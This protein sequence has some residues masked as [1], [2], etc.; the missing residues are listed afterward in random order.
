MH[1]NSSSVILFLFLVLAA[2]PGWCADA[3]SVYP[4]KWT[5]VEA[6]RQALK[7]NPDA[8][9]ARHRIEAARAAIS[10]A[11]AAFY[12]RLDVG[13]EYGGTD[14]PMFSFGNILNHGS[15]SNTINF[16][17]PGT[18]D[19]L[20]LIASLRYRLYNGGRDQAGLAAAKAQ[21]LARQQQQ[22][23]VLSTLADQ[24][25]R[26][27]YT[28]V[29]AQEIVAARKSAVTA[30]TASLAVA[31]AR[32]AAG[33]L[34]KA[35]L[36][37][38][39]VQQSAA[40]ERLIQARHGHELA[41]RAFLNLLGL[42]LDDV[43]LDVEEQFPQ[44]VPDN[45]D[46]SKRPE[47]KSLDAM[48]QAAEK[49]LARARAGYLPTADLFA[50]YQV[51]QGFVNESDSGNS[52]MAGV[53]LN[54][55]LFEGDRTRAAIAAA[56]AEL[57]R[58]K[59]LKRKMELAITL[60]I[61][62]AQLALKQARERLVVT[63]KQVRLARESARLFRERFKEGVILASNLMDAENRLTDALVHASIARAAH[64]IAIADL[65]RAAGF[66]QFPET[67][68][69]TGRSRSSS[70]ANSRHNTRQS[71]GKT[72]DSRPNGPG[73]TKKTDN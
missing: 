56:T 48:I 58:A 60:E 35:N 39:E 15:F 17:D 53:R 68:T 2:T 13:A 57:A 8:S 38:I 55:N 33:D 64:K 19:N 67:Q 66:A 27:F 46:P 16:N 51:D 49:Q 47:I 72:T 42:R 45:P 52:W 6:V 63:D 54:Y 34:L 20:R 28:I 37:D 10:Q 59:E 44:Q 29:Q 25:V 36:L 4:K 26:S 31:K 23:A 3:Q 9:I 1:K 61:E 43:Q 70:D 62:Q 40:H 11:R 12:P 69:D 71:A 21:H 32:Y 30:I 22:A 65:R 18:T 5:V 50:S 73:N 41:K 14:N 24:A 7:G